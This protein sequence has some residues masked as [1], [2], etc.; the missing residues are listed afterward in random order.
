MIIV[1]ITGDDTNLCDLLQEFRLQ[2]VNSLS[3]KFGSQNVLYTPSSR[4]IVVTTG[5]LLS[6]PQRY[7]NRGFILNRHEVTLMKYA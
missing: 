3:Q 5:F 2:A 7:F 6:F 1:H 4:L